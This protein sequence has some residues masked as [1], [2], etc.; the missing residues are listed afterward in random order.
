MKEGGSLLYYGASH[1]RDPQ[2]PQFA[3]INARWT[4]ARPTVAFYEGPRR[5]VADSEDE[6]IRR[7][8]ESGLVRW[9]AQ[10]DGVRVE[11]LEPEVQEE[12]DHLLREFPPEQ[13]KLFFVLREACR[14]RDVEHLGQKELSQAVASLLARASS[15]KGIGQV[16]ASVDELEAAYS[17][18]WSEPPNWWQA[19]NHWFDPMLTDTG[20]RFTNEVNRASS[21]FRNLHMYRRL[22]AEVLGGQ[23]VFAVV[24][25]DHVPMQMPAIDCKLKLPTS[26]GTTG[27]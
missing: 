19:P 25:R 22:S 2:H 13:V 24:G 17:R 21:H 26:R 6:T 8:G 16:I 20:G 27:S 14:L 15:L 9:L 12:V 7:F 1:S 11:R 18:H 5:P 3:E 23:R 10:R 4:Q